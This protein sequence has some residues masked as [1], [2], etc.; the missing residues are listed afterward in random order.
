MHTHTHT[1][2]ERE[3]EEEGE[4]ENKGEREGEGREDD[5]KD[6]F[7][8]VGMLTET[9]SGRLRNYFYFLLHSFLLWLLFVVVLHHLHCLNHHKGK[10][11]YYEK[12]KCK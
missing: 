9:L 3:R 11:L 4:G 12:I 2:A 7:Q 10:S 8:N 5:Y 1:K 6:I